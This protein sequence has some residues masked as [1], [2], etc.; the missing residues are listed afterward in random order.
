MGGCEGKGRGAGRLA[1][2]LAGRQGA[3]EREGG[4]GRKSERMRGGEE[5]MLT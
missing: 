5:I 4:C 1:G 3:K 2:R